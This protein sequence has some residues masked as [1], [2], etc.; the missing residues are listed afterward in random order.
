MN[1]AARA[2]TLGSSTI[3]ASIPRAELSVLAEM[4]RTESF[5]AGSTVVEAGE[6]ASCV[7][8]VAAGVLGVFLPGRADPVRQ[9]HVGEVLGEYGMV[10]AVRTA[11]VRA[12]GDATL[13]SLDYERFRAYLLRFPEALWILF[14]SSSRRL[15]E[16]ERR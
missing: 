9:L 7:F 14:E 3:F 15:L 2:L 16:A 11:T 12:E 13:L 6:T 5:P 4:M 10:G 1:A 8:V